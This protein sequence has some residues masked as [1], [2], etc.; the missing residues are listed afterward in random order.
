MATKRIPQC[1]LT[2]YL[3]EHFTARTLAHR[4]NLSTQ[5]GYDLLNGAMPSDD[6]LNRLGIKIVYEVQ[7]PPQTELKAATR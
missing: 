2:A 4:A 6:V 7:V 5:Y 3:K 1:E